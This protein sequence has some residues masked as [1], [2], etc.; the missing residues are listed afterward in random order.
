M[1]SVNCPTRA[2]KLPTRNH[3]TRPITDHQRRNALPT[4][5]TMVRILLTDA[6]GLI[7]AYTLNALLALPSLRTPNT[8]STNPH[9][10]LAGYHA[11]GELSSV[12]VPNPPI[13]G[14]PDGRARCWSPGTTRQ[15]TRRRCAA[16]TPCCS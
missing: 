1:I 4:R 10:I 11:P 2:S 5:T 9:T 7:G 15:R 8:T 14:A 6:V 12:P 3:K 13:P 16:S